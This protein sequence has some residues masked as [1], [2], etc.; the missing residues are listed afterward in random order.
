MP[1]ALH[2]LSGPNKMPVFLVHV[3]PTPDQKGSL[4][5]DSDQ[6][7]Q[8]GPR[9]SDWMDFVSE[10]GPDESDLIITKRQWGAF[11]GTELDLQLRRRGIDTIILCGIATN[12]GV[13][14]TARDAYERGYQQIFVED[15]CAGRSEGEHAHTMQT[16][17]PR[18]G[19]VR[20]TEDVLGVM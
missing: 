13:E 7:M 12:I 5:P 11:Y 19:K 10:M 3:G 1:P 18:I 9:P 15:A 20:L 2:K 8:L 16:I 14:S 4:H 17:F 6:P